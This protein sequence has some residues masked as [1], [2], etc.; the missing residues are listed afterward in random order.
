M[1]TAPIISALKNSRAELRA[2]TARAFMACRVPEPASVTAADV[3]CTAD[4]WGY[5]VTWRRQTAGLL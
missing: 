2:F 5:S 4:E 3:L 1:A